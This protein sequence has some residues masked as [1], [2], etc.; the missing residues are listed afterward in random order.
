MTIT[1]PVG[2]GGNP[3]KYPDGTVATTTARPVLVDARDYGIDGAGV[4]VFTT[5]MQTML[6]ASTLSG[7]KHFLLPA[8]LIKVDQKL[9]VPF[10][11]YTQIAGAGRGSTFLEQGASG[12][13]ILEVGAANTHSV[14]I[15]DMTVQYST[16]QTTAG[17]VAI[18]LRA[19]GGGSSAYW[20]TL[21]RLFIS[22][23][24]DGVAVATDDG[25]QA[26]WGS[27]FRDINFYGIKHSAVNLAPAAAVGNPA[28]RFDHIGV[29]NTGPNFPTGGSTGP[30]FNFTACEA[31]MDAIDVEGWD[32]EVIYAS[33]GGYC[34]VRGL[35]VESHRWSAA[36]SRVLFVANGV[37]DVENFN[38]TGTAQSTNTT[39]CTIASPNV[40]STLRL[41]NGEHN[42]D[43]TSSTA[44]TKEVIYTGP[45]VSTI[46]VDWRW[47][48]KRGGG[49]NQ[50]G[51]SA[52]ADGL[53]GLPIYGTTTSLPTASATYRGQTWLVLG[54]SGTA[55]TLATC[56]KA[57]GGTY[58]WKTLAT[59]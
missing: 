5:Q 44:G 37:L 26:F 27:S 15:R 55:D 25:Q 20:W 33:G 9:S 22:K 12:V 14:C 47:I 18:R 19:P 3:V 24:Y 39:Q 50:P 8:G 48:T 41:A 29:F 45:G 34:T 6:N 58:S 17:A 53:T 52:A 31:V 4:Q 56:M 54:G 36:T 21:E 43:T 2:G 10:A 46:N 35:H 13:P 11:P 32:N 38:I 16:P 23:A 7:P 57:S 30:A 51:P 59:G 40:G 49:L 28:L 42:V 1:R